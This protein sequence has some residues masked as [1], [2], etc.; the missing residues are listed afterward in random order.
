[1]II[2]LIK[3][4]TRIDSGHF[5][6]VSTKTDSTSIGNEVEKIQNR[7]YPI[8][9]AEKPPFIGVFI[10]KNCFVCPSKKISTNNTLSSI[11]HEHQINHLSLSEWGK[12][13]HH[14][15]SVRDYWRFI[16][17]WAKRNMKKKIFSQNYNVCLTIDDNRKININKQ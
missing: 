15:E 10:F 7:W 1:M 8:E 6:H 16:L 13:S 4:I 17:K 5:S 2:W 12:Q 11:Q 9:M 3:A 14:I